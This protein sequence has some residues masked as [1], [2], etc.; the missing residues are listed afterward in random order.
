[1]IANAIPSTWVKFRDAV[2][3]TARSV[4]FYVRAGRDTY[5]GIMTATDPEAAPIFKWD[6]LEARNSFCHY[7]E[8]IGSQPQRFGLSPL[9][10]VAVTAFLDIPSEWT[11]NPANVKPKTVL[12]ILDGARDRVECNVGL[13]PE[14][15]KPELNPIR[16]VIERFSNTTRADPLPEG[17]TMVAGYA[18]YYP[19]DCRVDR[20]NSPDFAF[21]LVRVRGPLGIATY[22]VDRWD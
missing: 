19:E 1:M 18:F 9:S 15:I 7:F 12:A 5:F 4:E 21:P 10:W 2:L 16:K 13:F 8:D 3:P 20:R 14:A 11:V 17:E 22:Q 6:T